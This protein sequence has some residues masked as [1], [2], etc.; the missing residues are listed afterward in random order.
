M[1]L[2]TGKRKESTKLLE[3]INDFSEVTGYK[4]NIEKSVVFLYTSNE[5][6][7]NEIK[8]TIPFIISWDRKKYLRINLAPRVQD[9]YTEN[10]KTF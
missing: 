8:N 7:K 6:P 4:I 5:E 1:I 2:C 10:C 3:L 9:L